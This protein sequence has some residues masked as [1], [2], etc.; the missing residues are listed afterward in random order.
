M[1][2]ILDIP[3]ELEP[4]QVEL[5]RAMPLVQDF[6]DRQLASDIPAVSR[7]C[8]QVDRYRG[9]ML[10]P[11]LT[12]LCGIAAHPEAAANRFNGLLTE[13]H[14]KSAAVCEM[15]HM[16]TLVHDDVLDEADSR[17]G[18]DTVNRLYGN[19]AAVI[20]GDYLI[21]SAYQ[22]CSTIDQESALA[23]ARASTTM[24]AGE[25]LQLDRRDDWSLDEPTYFE[26]LER[27]TAALIGVSCEL[28]ALHSGA[29]AHTRE[30]CRTFGTRLGVAFQIQDDLLDMT[31][32][33]AV[34][35]KSAGKDLEKGKL[36]LPLIHHLR[37]ASP[38]ARGR[39]LDAIRSASEPE[40][41]TTTLAR[42][43]LTEL[44]SSGSIEHARLTAHRLVAEAKE[45]LSRLAQSKAKELLM[46]MADAV[47]ARSY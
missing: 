22:L 8:R 25:L 40:G 37:S 33:E 42:S 41:P 19:E 10:R 23:V 14:A 31:G 17:R 27:K 5:S 6:F 1:R 24:C 15:V 21:A 38:L 46:I 36:T 9:K 35:G 32:R 3:A 29:D 7:L 30:A 16:A 4:V 39:T 11:T 12:L 26:I 13:K 2:H 18:G 34:T 44:E 45:K 47:V 43:I 28:G 20:L